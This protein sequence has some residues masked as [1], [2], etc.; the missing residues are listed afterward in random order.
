MA[1]YDVYFEAVASTHIRVEADS[2]E[3]AI[4]LA[5]EKDMP[6]ICAQCS[7]WGNPPGIELSDVWEVRDEQRDVIEVTDD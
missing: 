4:D 5:Y 7:G 6:D 3:D 1:V 2:K